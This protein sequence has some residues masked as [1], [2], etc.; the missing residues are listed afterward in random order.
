LTDPA[1]WINQVTARYYGLKSVRATEHV[2]TS[3]RAVY[4]KVGRS[5]ESRL[6]EKKAF[7]SPVAGNTSQVKLAYETKFE[8]GNW[9]EL[10]TWNIKDSS[11]AVLVEYTL[12][13]WPF[14]YQQ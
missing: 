3:R 1:F 14:R 4:D 5:L 12:E 6:V 9:V 8:K 10:F 13:K 7:A 11:H 2:S